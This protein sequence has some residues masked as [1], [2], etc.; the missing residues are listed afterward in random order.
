MVQGWSSIHDSKKRVERDAQEASKHLSTRVEQP[1][2]DRQR[3]LIQSGG[4]QVAL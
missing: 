3:M 1:E 2:I 4:F